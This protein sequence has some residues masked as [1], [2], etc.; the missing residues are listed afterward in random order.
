MLYILL[1][2]IGLKLNMGALYWIIYTLW[3]VSSPFIYL[4]KHYLF[5]ELDKKNNK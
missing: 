4:V 2:L 3:I 5:K 1:L